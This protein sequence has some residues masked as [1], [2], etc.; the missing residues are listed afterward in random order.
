MKY[1]LLS[2]LFG[3]GIAHGG[4]RTVGKGGGYA[5]MQAILINSQMAFWSE[6][7]L[8]TPA[9]CG[10]ANEEARRLKAATAGSFTLDVNPQC[11]EPAIAIHAPDAATLASCVLY[12][13]G[14]AVAKDF[15][16]IAGWVLVARLMASQGDSLESAQVLALK[17]F[18]DYQQQEQRLAVSL[19][20]S[21]VLF[22]SLQV[23]RDS[24]SYNIIS[25]EGKTSAFDITPQIENLL[26]CG[27]GALELLGINPLGFQELAPTKGVV[28]TELE[29]R[30]RA[31]SPYRATLQL[32]FAAPQSEILISSVILK[33]VKKTG[34]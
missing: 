18:R 13:D 1:V 10:L 32:F 2:F 30:C 34:L 17:V 27:P 12:R 15:R 24:E 16:D 9:P 21:T 31:A 19:S 14:E 11:T 7:C 4:V 22:H 28:E 6:V 3:T 5:E 26:G 25:L 33:L 29:W 20:E 23:K 8:K